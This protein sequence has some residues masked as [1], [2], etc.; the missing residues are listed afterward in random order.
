MHFGMRGTIEQYNLC[1][2]DIIALKQDASGSEYTNERATET[3]I[4]LNPRDNRLYKPKVCEL[5][6]IPDHCPVRL[7]EL[8][9]TNFFF[10]EQP[11]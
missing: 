10:S 8:Y 5:L 1:W 9:S 4:G 2:G 11:T 7:F 6:D 3:C